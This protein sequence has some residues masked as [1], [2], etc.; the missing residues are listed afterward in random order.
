MNMLSQ[1]IKQSIHQ[2]DAFLENKTLGRLIVYHEKRQAFLELEIG[3]HIQLND[4]FNIEILNCNK[5]IPVTFEE[6][7][8]TLSTDGCALYAGK[9]CRIKKI[10]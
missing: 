7:I 5:W 2:I 4:S 10:N 3:E 8:T 6:V 1:S 9:T